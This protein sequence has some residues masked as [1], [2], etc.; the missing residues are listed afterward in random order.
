MTVPPVAIVTG[1]GSG[2]GRETC[3]LLALEGWHMTLVGRTETTL[4]ATVDLLAAEVADPPDVLVL[5]LDVGD[6]EQACSAVDMTVNEWGRVDALVNNAASCPVRALPDLEQDELFTTFA[7]NTFGP[8]HMVTRL[9]PIFERQHGG[10]VVNVSSMATVDPF[11]GLGGY[12]ASKAALESVTRSILAEGSAF[13][14]QAYSVAPGAV[15]TAM[16]RGIVSTDD[17]PPAQTLD[18]AEVAAVIVDCA[19][20]ERQDDLGRVIYLP[21]G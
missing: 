12:A 2:I 19:R 4:Q 17:L 16:L 6:P 11:P 21:S 15:E 18:P 1:A 14:M 5:P 8:M 13:G 9:W 3:R 7:V 10:C 20:G